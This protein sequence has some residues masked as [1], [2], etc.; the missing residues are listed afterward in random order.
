MRFDGARLDRRRARLG[1]NAM[2]VMMNAARLHVGLQ[3]ISLLSRLAKAG[4]YAQERRQM[5]AP[6]SS[7]K[8][9]ESDPLGGTRPCAASLDTNAW[10][11]A[12]RVIGM[13][14]ARTRHTKHH[15]DAARLG[16]ARWYS[17]VTQSQVGWTGRPS[18][19]PAPACR[20]SAATAT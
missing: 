4:A 3:G 1:L 2:F 14:G 15:P 16:A 10:I 7:A 5:R 17:L 13:H 18:A 9:G 8:A 12:R 19:A 20:S 6:G 11:D